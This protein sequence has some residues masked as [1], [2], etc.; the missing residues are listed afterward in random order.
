M[1]L[2]IGAKYEAN[3]H[4]MTVTGHVA[5]K[6]YKLSMS[7]IMR[8]KNDKGKL[9]LQMDSCKATIGSVDV[10]FVDVDSSH[11]ANIFNELTS[12]DFKHALKTQL[13]EELCNYAK[14]QFV[15]LLTK[16]FTDLPTSAVLFDNYY[17]DYSLIN[18][19]SVTPALLETL[20]RGETY[21]SKNGI[22]DDQVPF[23]SPPISYAHYNL[24]SNPKMVYVFMSNY[25]MSTLMYYLWKNKQLDYNVTKEKVK[26]DLANY[27]R[28]ECT[29][30]EMCG[31]TIWPSLKK[32]YPKSYVDIYIKP[33]APPK[34]A[35]YPG[36]V[37]ITNTGRI[38]SYVRKP[39][40][41]RSFLFSSDAD[42]LMYIKK[43]DLKDYS[44]FATIKIGGYELRNFK[45]SLDEVNELSMDLLMEFAKGI[46]FEPDINQ[47]LKNGIILP[48]MLN[49][50]MTNGTVEIIQDLL[51]AST[52][53]CVSCTDSK[54][55]GHNYE[56]YYNG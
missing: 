51:V 24:A 34:V 3:L 36:T 16:T 39:D 10:E 9:S 45:S 4:G 55:E 19:P 22:R 44:L 12:P 23:A 29:S 15:P 2:T 26:P 14:N 11:S 33:T 25:S 27:L 48:K 54:K 13:Q 7:V 20:H 6:V 49:F 21:V 46:F 56:E 31:S 52:D 50:D 35:I 18:D 40:N 30:K 1:S 53:F 28:T 42:L 32:L 8:T 43:I 41:S 47:L 37:N 5:I 17:F 38:E